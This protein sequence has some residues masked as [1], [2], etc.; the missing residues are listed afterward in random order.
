MLVLLLACRE[1][2]AERQVLDSIEQAWQLCE[3][4]LHEAGMRAERLRESASKSSEYVRQKYDLLTIRLRDKCDVVPSGLDSALQTMEYFAARDNALDKE[5]ACYYAGSAYRDLKDYPR[6][7]SCFLKAVNAA[8]QA[9]EADT[10]IW[11]NSLSQM[12]HLYM[13]QLNYEE[14]LKAAQKA[15]GLARHTGR[16]LGWCM[17]DVASAYDHLGDTAR[18]LQCCNQSY[19]VY[20][21]E[22]FPAKYCGSIAYMLVLYSKYQNYGMVDTL[23]QHLKL[24]PADQRPQNYELSLARSFENKNQADSAILHYKSYYDRTG[25]LSGRYEAAAGLQRCYRQ[26]GDSGSAAEWGC[27]L[28][29]TNDSIIAQRAFEQTQRARNEY[30]YHRDKEEEQAIVRRDERII[31]FSVMAGLALTSIIMGLTAFYYFRKKKF[32]DVIVGMDRKLRS[33]KEEIRQRSRELEQK[34][35]EIDRLG[36]QLDEAERTIAESQIRFEHVLKDLEQRTMVNK[37]L[38][39]IAL[40]GNAEGGAEDVIDYFK[41]AS[42]GQAVL[43]PSS[44]RELMAATEAIYPGFLEAVQGRMHGSIREPLLRTICL[45][46]IGLKPVQIARVMDAKIQTVWN[47]VKRAEDIC[48]DLLLYRAGGN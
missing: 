44:W 11:Q 26:K 34:K 37:E 3:D 16:N 2:D 24:L 45:L 25:L 21:D 39:R 5:R 6:A 41:M 14:E 36:S 15:V 7:V 4:S 42:Q 33:S 43:K 8:E 18:C 32:M 31:L 48:G 20:R 23:M 29:D 22:G 46:K 10:L 30:V 38:T 28:Y 40:L 17:M 9:S 35:Q 19:Q 27:R 13:L 47:R 1:D 12:R